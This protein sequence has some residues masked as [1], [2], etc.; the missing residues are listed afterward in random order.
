MAA[1]GVSIDYY[2]SKSELILGILDKCIM[3]RYDTSGFV[4]SFA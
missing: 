1:A 3:C 2:V 4:I